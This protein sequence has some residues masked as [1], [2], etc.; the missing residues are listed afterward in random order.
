MLYI[1]VYINMILEDIL[2][3]YWSEPGIKNRNSVV[4][5]H[6]GSNNR[7]IME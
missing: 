3:V 4:S 7:V 1:L 6:H 5:T 2:Y